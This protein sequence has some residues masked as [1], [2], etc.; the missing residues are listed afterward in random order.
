[1]ARLLKKQTSFT[2]YRQP[3]RK[4]KLLFSVFSTVLCPLYDLCPSRVLCPLYALC[5]LNG[6]LS[7]SKAL[8]LLYGCLSV[9]YVSLQ[10]SVPSTAL[11]PLCG[12]PSPL[13]PS[14]PSIALCPLYGSLSPLWPSVTSTTLCLLF[15]PLPPLRSSTPSLWPSTPSLWPSTPSTSLCP[16]CGPLYLY[17]PL[18]PL[19]Y[20]ALY[21]FWN[22][23]FLTISRDDAIF[24]LF[25]ETRFAER[26][27]FEK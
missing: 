12:P 4:N 26:G 3:A 8:C 2:V 22:M 5:P 7:P 27:H 6:L 11:C 20:G 13:Q 18:S 16:L 1:M 17:G 14:V 24:L 9:P 21:P 25:S 23:L 10:P 15:S 19:L